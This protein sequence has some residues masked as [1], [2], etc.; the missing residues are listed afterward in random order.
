MDGYGDM[1][2]PGWIFVGEFGFEQVLATR[3]TDMKSVA[4]LTIMV[5]DYGLYLFSYISICR[6]V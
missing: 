3:S 2:M 5:I 1:T 6:R 4:K